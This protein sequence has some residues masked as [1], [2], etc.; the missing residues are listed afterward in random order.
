[1]PWCSGSLS[2]DELELELVPEL[3]PELELLELDELA[4]F[5]WCFSCFLWCLPCPCSASLSLDELELELDPELEL[6]EL[7]EL[8]AFLWCFT[9][10]L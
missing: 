9:C 10:F 7:D 5:L 3:D 4:A 1:L 2:L 6:L 8:A